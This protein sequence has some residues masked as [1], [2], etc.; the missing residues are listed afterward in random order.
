MKK[1]DRTSHPVLVLK[2]KVNTNS[3]PVRQQVLS[4]GGNGEEEVVKPETCS[5]CGKVNQADLNKYFF[6]QFNPFQIWQAVFN[7]NLH[8]KIHTVNGN[9]QADRGEQQ[10]SQTDLL[11]IEKWKRLYQLKECSVPLQQ[12][13]VTSLKV[14]IKN[15]RSTRWEF[16]YTHNFFNQ[17]EF[18][19]FNF[20]NFFCLYIR[21]IRPSPGQ[22][23]YGHGIDYWPWIPKFRCTAGRY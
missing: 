18:K 4:V 17:V 2:Q 16:Q 8:M 13:D 23:L 14:W 21:M 1:T 5:C 12:L 9:S 19:Q 3:Q 22:Y 20:F 7:L 11:F 15:K 10:L 6:S